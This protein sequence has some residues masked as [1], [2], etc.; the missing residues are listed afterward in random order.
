LHRLFLDRLSVDLDLWLCWLSV[1][2]NLRLWLLLLWRL[3]SWLLDSS[4]RLDRLLDHRLS[5]WSHWSGWLSE[6]LHLCLDRSNCQCLI[7]TQRSSSVLSHGLDL[8]HWLLGR[9][10]TVEDYID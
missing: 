3:L 2:L 1:Y 4:Y 8:L 10:R 7:Y 9:L 5:D 6:G